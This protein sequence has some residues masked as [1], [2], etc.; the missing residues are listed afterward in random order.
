MSK[1]IPQYKVT[2]NRMTGKRAVVVG[3]DVINIIAIKA[4]TSR[5]FYCHFKTGKQSRLY[6]TLRDCIINIVYGV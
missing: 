5:N 4:G 1:F 2:F 3:N 6:P